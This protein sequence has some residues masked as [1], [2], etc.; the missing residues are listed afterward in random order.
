VAQ[1]LTFF[2]RLAKKSP[3]RLWSENHKNVAQEAY[4]PHLFA[5]LPTE[6][7]QEVSSNWTRIAFQGMT[8]V[9]CRGCGNQFSD[10]LQNCPNCGRDKFAI[11][12]AQNWRCQV[13]GATNGP[14]QAVC[15]NSAK[16]PPGK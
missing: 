8:T 10:R 11:M 14:E 4:S 5:T 6:E 3:N 7:P 12:K 2:L 15:W 16:H 13:C 1:K 9:T